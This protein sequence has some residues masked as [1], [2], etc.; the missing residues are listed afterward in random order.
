MGKCWA[1]S[2]GDCSDKQ[3]GE[4]IVSKGLFVSPVV[5]VQGL[6]WCKEEPKIVGINSVTKNILCTRHNSELSPVDESAIAAFNVFRQS[7]EF[8]NTREKMNERRWNIIQLKI[9]GDGLERWFLKTLINVAV[10]GKEKIGRLSKVPGQPSPD[11]VEIAYGKRKFSGSAGLYNSAE[12]GEKI[13]S[14]DRVTV[15][16]FLDAAKEFVIGAAFRFRGFRFM[17]TLEEAGFTDKVTFVDKNG[18]HRIHSKPVRHLK[19]IRVT[20]GPSQYLSHR[21]SFRWR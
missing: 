10:G 19:H 11:L 5:S 7:V 1:E 18:A 2:L 21:I 6:S 17:L 15:L 8:T 14:E 4:H 12:L 3:S 20:I 9:D 13:D 16:T